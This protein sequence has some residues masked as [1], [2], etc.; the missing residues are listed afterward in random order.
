MAQTERY[1]VK[2]LAADKQR[3]V[4]LQGL[5]LD[6]FQ[7]TAVQRANAGLAIDGLLTLEQV[8]SLVQAGYQVLVE[9]HESQR[10]RARTEVADFSRW[11]QSMEA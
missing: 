7:S 5:G 10:A 9:E 8:G 4:A 6:L 3:L 1:F 11:L 2:V